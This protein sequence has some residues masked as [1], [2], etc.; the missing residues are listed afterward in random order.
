MQLFGWQTNQIKNF[1]TVA[2]Q[3]WDFG[4]GLNIKRITL[5]T[6]NTSKN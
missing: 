4:L 5:K 2:T 1:E 6:H 3:S